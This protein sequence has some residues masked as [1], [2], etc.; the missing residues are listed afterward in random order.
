MATATQDRKKKTTEP[1]WVEG[2]YHM[3]ITQDKLRPELP[4]L[5]FSCLHIGGLDFPFK[6]ENPKHDPVTGTTDRN[7]VMGVKRLLRQHMLDSIERCM[8]RDVFRPNP[9]FAK[10]RRG[11]IY[12][13][14]HPMYHSQEEDRPVSDFIYLVKIEEEDLVEV[15]PPSI[16][17]PEALD[18]SD[19]VV[20][21]ED[22]P[23][24]SDEE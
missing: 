17:E 23:D 5:G 22:D 6:T 7:P 18:L 9:G 20:V 4:S 10:N 24:G 19:T 11:D 15:T 14:K 1:K 12:N 2:Y 21:M 8:D 3:G 16:N 13:T